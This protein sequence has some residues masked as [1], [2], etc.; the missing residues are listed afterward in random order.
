VKGCYTP[1][2]LTEILIIALVVIVVI[3]ILKALNVL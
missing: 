3:A 2:M 1:E